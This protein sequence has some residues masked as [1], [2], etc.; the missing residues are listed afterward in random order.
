MNKRD[1]RIAGKAGGKAKMK[2][3]GVF[4]EALGESLTS[5]ISGNRDLMQAELERLRKLA[6][7]QTRQNRRNQEK[8]RKISEYGKQWLERIKARGE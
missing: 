5:G 1:R 6:E 2:T 4:A 8:L 7:R 3:M